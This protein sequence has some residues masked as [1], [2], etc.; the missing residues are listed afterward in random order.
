[1][2]YDLLIFCLCTALFGIIKR[3]MHTKHEDHYKHL[4]RKNMYLEYAVKIMRHD[5]QSGI[6]VYM[7]RGITMLKRR[8]TQQQIEDLHLSI[9]MRLLE[10]GLIHTQ[11]VYMGVKEF[12]ELVKPN[13]LLKK[14]VHSL[15]KIL[16]EYLS[17]CAYAESVLIDSLP[18]VEVN[19]H[20][21]CIA[22]DNL[23]RNGLKY[24]DHDSKVVIITMIEDMLCVID[25]G[26]GMSQKDF[27]YLSKPY[28]RKKNQKESGT[29]LGLN[30]SLAILE[31]H[32]F[33]AFASINTKGGTTIRIK[34][35]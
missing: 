21:F 5:M 27:E 8:L 17:N 30:I 9:P 14:E 28:V 7:P 24:N 31:E 1:M 3:T 18:D 10:D 15:D 11:R 16:T 22:I 2:L 35:K 25:N 20:L 6:N 19:K 4:I 12:T 23:I 13:A 34:I 33:T 29:G 32:N 26:R